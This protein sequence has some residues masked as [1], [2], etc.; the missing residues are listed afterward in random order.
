M[1]LD[2]KFPQRLQRHSGLPHP[3][4]GAS[5]DSIYSFLTAAAHPEVRGGFELKS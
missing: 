2:E 4:V 1:R 5:H 3:D